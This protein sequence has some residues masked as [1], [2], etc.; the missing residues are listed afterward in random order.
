MKTGIIRYNLAERGRQYRG[1]ERNFDIPAI[2]RAI[3]S[4]VTQ[5]KVRHRDML[6]Y[7]GHWP[8]VKFGMNP[9]EG[10]IID[11][12]VIPVEPAMVTI[13]LKAYDDGTIEHEEEFSDDTLPGM[14]AQR[15][16]KSKMG[17]F[18][19]AIDERKPEFF[20]FDYVTE[21]N[22][23][24]NR[25]YELALDSAGVTLDSIVAVNEYNAQLMG[26]LGLLDS[27]NGEHSKAMQYQ[28]EVEQQLRLANETIVRMAEE[29][30]QYISM[31]ARGTN[32]LDSLE[33]IMP[34]ITD[35]R[36]ARDIR[37]SIKSF[38][39]AELVK[40]HI[41]ENEPSPQEREQQRTLSR[42]LR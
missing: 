40:I 2:V 10:G 28:R 23:T 30:D 24:T 39:T 1:T 9:S 25:G 36:R 19:S 3:N 7:F 5:E 42:F 4:G 16:Y 34:L 8:R 6:G 26:V 41:P 11:G 18:S 12:K 15:M 33:A 32:T 38:H 35:P 17:G 27:L 14:I 13:Y 31:I 37:D 21:P 22:Y 20:G 29:N